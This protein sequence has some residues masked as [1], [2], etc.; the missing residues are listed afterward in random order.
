MMSWVHAAM[1]NAQHKDAFTDHAV[2]DG[3]RQALVASQASANEIV[4]SPEARVFGG[5]RNFCGEGL[6]LTLGRR[7]PETLDPVEV[8]VDQITLGVTGEF[9]LRHAAGPFA[10]LPGVR[11]PALRAGLVC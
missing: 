6:G 4:V 10:V 7:A 5:G 2:V 11:P 3:V 8:D 9:S 1:Q